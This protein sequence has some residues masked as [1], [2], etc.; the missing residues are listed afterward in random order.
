MLT[1]T[2]D[3][4]AFLTRDIHMLPYFHGNRS[5]RANPHLTGMLTG[6]KLSRTP[7]DMALQYLA[8]IQ[9]I[10]LGT[11]HIVETMNQSGYSIDTIMASGGGTK[12]PIFVQEH[13]NRISRSVFCNDEHAIAKN[14]PSNAATRD[15]LAHIW[16]EIGDGIDDLEPMLLIV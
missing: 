7:E 16:R 5:P 13:A 12:N 10:A 3:Q 9:A 8:T 11:R 15:R 4:I 14:E 6:L 1:L 2:D